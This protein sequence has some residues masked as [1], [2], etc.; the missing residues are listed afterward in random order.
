MSQRC[1]NHS[2]RHLWQPVRISALTL[3]N[4][5]RMYEIDAVWQCRFCGG[6]YAYT[7]YVHQDVPG[8]GPEEA[9]RLMVQ[10]QH[11]G[12]PLAQSAKAQ[13]QQNWRLKRYVTA[14]DTPRH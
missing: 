14:A 8:G 1:H 13:M 7:G 3:P 4:I 5:N 2:G 11:Q 6:T 12:T 10:E 9:Q